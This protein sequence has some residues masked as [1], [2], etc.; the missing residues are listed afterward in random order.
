VEISC[1]DKGGQWEFS[2]ADNGP[3]IDPR[4]HDKIFKIFQTLQA[5]DKFE[6]TG[7]GLSIIKKIVE[8]NNGRIWLESEIGKGTTFFFT[9]PK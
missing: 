7:I 4:Y 5:R 1:E 9:L 8:Q 2:V 3:G 6:S